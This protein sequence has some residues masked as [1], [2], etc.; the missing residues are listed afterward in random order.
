MVRMT[1]I[2][3]KVRRLV[4]RLTPAPVCSA[5]L[6]DRLGDVPEN[7]VQIS[8]SELAAEREFARDNDTC[9]LCG[10]HR[11]VIRKRK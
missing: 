6:A 1:E 5:C 10:E 8:L 2:L 3:G 9:S 4:E 7:E 11:P